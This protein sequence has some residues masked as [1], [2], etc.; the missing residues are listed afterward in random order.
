[1]QYQLTMGKAV[2]LITSSTKQCV[3]RMHRFLFCGGNCIW[4]INK[5][6]ASNSSVFDKEIMSCKNYNNNQNLNRKTLAQFV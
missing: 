6:G 4:P 3:E 5:G 1:M 2:I